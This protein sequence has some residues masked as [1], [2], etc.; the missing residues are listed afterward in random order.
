L[1][2]IGAENAVS[3][4]K[5]SNDLRFRFDMRDTAGC[6]CEQIIEAQGLGNGHTRYGC[7]I[8][9]MESWISL[10]IP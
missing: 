8:D 4:A 1:L 7:S 5:R 10:V 2:L 9:A 3:A 6:S